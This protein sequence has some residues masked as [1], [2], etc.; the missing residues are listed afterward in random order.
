[1]TGPQPRTPGDLPISRAVGQNVRAL[2]QLHGWSQRELA[3]R[4]ETSG[5]GRAVDFNTVCRMERSREPAAT[6]VAVS[7]DTL[8]SL[9]AVLGVPPDRLLRMPQ[10]RAC[11][12][13]PPPGF[14]CRS[15]GATA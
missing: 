14:A 5:T 2:R 4:T 6:P 1:M 8:V 9:A 10:C 11:L 3:R 13:S 15:C 7:V 12:D